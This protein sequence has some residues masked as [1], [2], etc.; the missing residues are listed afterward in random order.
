MIWLITL[1]DLSLDSANTWLDQSCNFI[2]PVAKRWI[3]RLMQ[4]GVVAVCEIETVY[5]T[6]DQTHSKDCVLIRSGD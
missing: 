5:K 1:E 3:G 6:C 2:P 4:I